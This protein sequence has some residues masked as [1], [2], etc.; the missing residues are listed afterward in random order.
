MLR[1]FFTSLVFHRLNTVE[2]VFD[3]FR[4]IFCKVR[5]SGQ[6]LDYFVTN[7]IYVDITWNSVAII[8]IGHRRD[9]S[10]AK[11]EVSEDI[12]SSL[13]YS[14]LWYAY[15]PAL[16]DSELYISRTNDRSRLWAC[17]THL[18]K[19]TPH[20]QC[21]CWLRSFMI[22]HFIKFRIVQCAS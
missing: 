10:E 19:R 18:I 9:I 6:I 14:S 16:L 17:Q 8:S 20:L 21:I 4:F 22:L 7:V 2:W 12:C 15:Y 13:W 1:A 5:S 3:N 11:K